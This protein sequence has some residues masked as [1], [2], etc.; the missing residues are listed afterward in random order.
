V[1]PSVLNVGLPA[2]QH[3]GGSVWGDVGQFGVQVHRRG[4]G[5]DVDSQPDRAGEIERAA[6]RL[7]GEGEHVGPGLHGLLVG[8][9]VQEREWVGDGGGDQVIRVVGPVHR[10][11]GGIAAPGERAAV[12]VGGCAAA[13]QV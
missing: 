7:G 13:S 5:A 9:L 8:E 11:S 6:G 12:G 10:R 4:T 2:E 3:A 1:C